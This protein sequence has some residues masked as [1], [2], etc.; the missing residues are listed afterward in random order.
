[1]KFLEQYLTHSKYKY[2]EFLSLYVASTS[3]L[4]INGLT[5]HIQWVNRFDFLIQEAELSHPWQ[6]FQF[7]TSSQF[8]KVFHSDICLI[9]CLLVTTSLWVSYIQPT[10]LAPPPPTCSIYFVDSPQRAPLSHWRSAL[11]SCPL[12]LKSTSYNSPPENHLG[13]DLDP[14]KG[15]DSQV[16]HSLSL[17]FPTWQLNVCVLDSLLP[18]GPEKCTA[19]F[20]LGYM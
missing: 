16:S 20:S 14:N 8:F 12:A 17:L 5:F 11:N 7:S 19:V 3:I 15:F 10:L 13:N 18:V 2:T 1:M 4:N 6:S 9:N